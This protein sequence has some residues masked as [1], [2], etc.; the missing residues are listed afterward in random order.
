MAVMA[1]E[2]RDA[3]EPAP[4]LRA[5]VV[6]AGARWLAGQRQ[7]VRLVAELQ[8]SGEWVVDGSATCAHWVAGALDIEVS[9]VREWL[10]IGRKL[11]RLPIIDAAFDDGRLS[12]SKVR[13]LTRIATPKHEVELCALAERVSG[14]RAP[15]CARGMAASVTRRPKRP[16][17]GITRRAGSGGE[18]TSTGCG[19]AAS[20]SRPRS[21]PSS[22]RRSTPRSC[23]AAGLGTRPRTRRASRFR[24]PRSPSNG[25]MRSSRCWKAAAPRS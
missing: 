11:G 1:V 14:R 7:L 5:K 3:E 25:P 19:P 12:Y 9:T 21:A 22:R 6:A 20:G 10:R 18:T 23:A 8:S 17:L 15:A 2:H 24:G 13:A 4:S 16:K